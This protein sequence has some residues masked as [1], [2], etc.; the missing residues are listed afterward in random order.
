MSKL[1]WSGVRRGL[2]VL[3]ASIGLLPGS[4]AAQFPG[5]VFFLEPSVAI[6]EDGEA[7]LDIGIF[8]GSIALGAAQ[9]EIGFDEEL[10]EL[11]EVR[12]GPEAGLLLVSRET[13]GR[14]GVANL[15]AA[16]LEEPFAT[17]TA[18]HIAFRAK[19]PAGTRIPIAIDVVEVLDAQTRP[20]SSRVGFSGELVVTSPSSLAREPSAISSDV[21]PVSEESELGKRLLS[22]RR[23]GAIIGAV[24]AASG[25]VRRYQ[26]PAMA[27][28]S[29]SD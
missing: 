16:S 12:E 29:T 7:E 2:A 21:T 11:V 15:N 6:P 14:L 5:D 24:D 19:A 23:P 27:S 20:F 13:P 10:A 22:M 9:Y 17:V 4:A 8:T 26:V 18:A 1:D 28:T 3:L 25:E